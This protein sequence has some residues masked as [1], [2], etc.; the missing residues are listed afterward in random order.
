MFPMR[1]LFILYTA[2]LGGDLETLPR[3]HTFLKGLRAESGADRTLLLDLGGSCAP[4]IWHCTAT[5]GR[6][7]L[8][9]LDAMG[10]TAANAVDVSEG[11]RAR[12]QEN[13]L[14]MALVDDQHPHQ[15][16]S[17]LLRTATAP[18]EQRGMLELDLRPAPQTAFDGR[19][20]RLTG[21][22]GDQVGMA[23]LR[24]EGGIP[25][26]DSTAVYDLP[27]ETL[28]DATI[29]ATVSFVLAEAQR[30]QRRGLT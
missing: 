24:L 28:P 2:N 19:E 20:L 13:F 5:E 27:P 21:L 17:L 4:G 6:S 30:Y 9:T 15:L 1:D 3:L 22:K 7:M 11:S 18:N 10:Y 25:T 29:S 26:L 8:I 16:E 12:L 14:A 23:R